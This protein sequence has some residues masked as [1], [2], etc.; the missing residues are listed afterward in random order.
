MV[1]VEW[2][3]KQTSLGYTAK[4]DNERLYAN[5]YQSGPNS[6]SLGIR[7]YDD[8]G[9]SQGALISTGRLGEM[10]FFD[11]LEQITEIYQKAVRREADALTK[12]TD[13]IRIPSAPN[14]SFRS[15][16]RQYR[17]LKLTAKTKKLIAQ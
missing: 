14:K 15:R 6:Y 12:Q 2:Q 16:K 13:N 3:V 7:L 5:V 10:D 11:A 4:I 8:S 1:N 17:K 9:R